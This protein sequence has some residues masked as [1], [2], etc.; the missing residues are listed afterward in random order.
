MSS[1]ENASPPMADQSNSTAAPSSPDRNKK[2]RIRNWTADDRAAHRVFERSRREAFKERLTTLASLIPSLR[3]TDPNRLSKHVVIDQSVALHKAEQ[4]EI[5]ESLQRINRLVAERDDL[6][7]ELNT[8]RLNA[9]LEARQVRVTADDSETTSVPILDEAS[10]SM[11]RTGVSSISVGANN[12]QG[13]AGG[14]PLYLEEQS[15]FV[16]TEHDLTSE[17]VMARTAETNLPSAS[18]SMDIPWMSTEMDFTIPNSLTLAADYNA[19]APPK[20]PSYTHLPMPYDMATNNL[21]DETLRFN[22]S[23]MHMA[24]PSIFHNDTYIYTG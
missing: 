7:S 4:K 1:T 8:W 14:R 11:L 22:T 5:A 24:D 12:E 17:P 23:M 16:A 19:A 3:S 2:K 9:G 10:A 15:S 13:A 18:M 20:S 21:E 6:L